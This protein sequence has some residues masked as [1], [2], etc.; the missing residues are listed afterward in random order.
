MLFRSPGFDPWVGKMPW[1]R[2]RLPTPV[3][4]P[5]EFHGLYS[6][7]GHKEADTAGRLALHKR[8]EG[9][10]RALRS[11]QVQTTPQ[12]RSNGSSS[13]EAASRKKL[14][15]LWSGGLGPVHLSSLGLSCSEL[16]EKPHLRTGRNGTWRLPCASLESP[17]PTTA[18]LQ[19]LAVLGSSQG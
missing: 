9:R 4:W 15:S 13:A 11:A 5:G 17:A 12:Q 1:R 16:R 10:L 7:R 6:P 14:W 8:E 3:F 19:R 18:L 2:A